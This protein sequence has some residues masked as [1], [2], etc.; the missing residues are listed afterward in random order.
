MA[1]K[2]ADIKVGVVTNYDDKGIKS[3]ETGLA[4][5]KKS[6]ASADGVG[7]KLKAGWASATDSIKANA[8][9]LAMAG[10][11]ALV[12]FG[13]KAVGAFTS[14]AKEAID[15]STATGLSIEEASRW[16]GVADDYQ[17]SAEALATG[18]GKI[19]KTLDATKWD[20]YGIK[21][22]DAG[23]A[24]RDTNDILLDSFDMLS[25]V[26]NKTEQARIGQELFGKG[27]QSL[28]PILGHTRAEYEKMLGAVEKGQVITAK[29][30]AKAEKFRLAQD[31][32]NDALKEFTLAAGGVVA[33]YGPMVAQ[34]ASAITK[35]SEFAAAAEDAT[36]VVG[37]L[38]NAV[39]IFTQPWGPAQAAIAAATEVIDTNAM[40]LDE[41]TATL[42][43][44]NITGADAATITQ[45]WYDAH[46]LLN[47]ALAETERETRKLDGAMGDVIDAEQVAADKAAA[48][49]AQVDKTAGEVKADIDAMEV[50]WRGLHD[51]VDQDKAWIGIQNQVDDVKLALIDA[52]TALKEKGP[53]S[54]EAITANRDARDKMDDLKNAVITYGK[55][56]LGLPPEK[57]TELLAKIDQQ[58]FDSVLGDMDA[59]LAN[60]LFRIN[61]HLDSIVADGETHVGGTVKTP[62]GS[63][64]TPLKGSFDSGGVI[65]GP[66]GAPVPVL[67]HGGEVVLNKDQ[68]AALNG[69]VSGSGVQIENLTIVMPPGSDG[70]SI[71]RELKKFERRNG[72]GWRT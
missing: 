50:K 71:V 34:T 56:I 64:I 14:V 27:Y 57:V 26:T 38:K 36:E 10:G 8:G 17:V 28:T 59:Q 48:Y 68:Q 61:A 3:A 29:E 54:P 53:S 6:I 58:N 12:T 22:R 2:Q 9:T 67:A 31:Q 32:L 55:E 44:A 39:E 65:P 11:A 47:P 23:G 41:M 60:H 20:K 70:N 66:L 40:S 42:K 13:V 5:F 45:A 43:E 21:T 52:G 49:S 51:M 35:V 33:A 15:L 19:A 46:K 72:P 16:V 4:G 37:G 30:A 62:G 7:G 25:K 63:T 69:G 18:L 24:A 1:G